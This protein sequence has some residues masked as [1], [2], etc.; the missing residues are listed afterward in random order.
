MPNSLLIT[1]N[2]CHCVLFTA[3]V[4]L[5]NLDNFGVDVTG[6]LRALHSESFSGLLMGY[7]RNEAEAAVN[8]ESL[9][10]Y[11]MIY[12]GGA[13]LI[14]TLGEFSVLSV[15]GNY[16]MQVHDVELYQHLDGY[17]TSGS[18]RYSYYFLP[19]TAIYFEASGGVRVYPNGSNP[20]D[21]VEFDEQSD[22]IFAEFMSGVEGRLS[23]T[24]SIHASAGF[25]YREYV[26]DADFAEPIFRLKFEEQLS[27]RDILVAGFD[28]R[29]TDSYYTNFMVDQTISLGYGRILGDQILVLGRAAYSALSFSLPNRREDQRILGEVD[30]EYSYTSELKF[31]AQFTLDLLNS[32][33]RENFTTTGS[34][35]DVPDPGVS[36]EALTLAAS[37][38]YLF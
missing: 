36:Y 21:E 28:Y 30:F 32:D 16:E 12:G 15:S 8:S 19:E 25:L 5:D 38:K 3:I 9:I 18:A 31:G 11:R 1:L 17:D 26:V 23:D 34:L 22:S 14:W 13:K 4:S 2:C 6:Q 7:A 37:A 10:R 35:D 27:P 20:I 29:V 33:A 24:T